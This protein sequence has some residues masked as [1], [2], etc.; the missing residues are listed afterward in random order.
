MSKQ[1]SLPAAGAEAAAPKPPQRSRDLLRAGVDAARACTAGVRLCRGVWRACRWCVL[2]RSCRVCVRRRSPQPAGRRRRRCRRTAAAAA[3]RRRAAQRTCVCRPPR[4]CARVR[5]HTLPHAARLTHPTFLRCYTVLGRLQAFVPQLAAANVALATAMATRPAHEFDVE[6]VQPSGQGGEA[7]PHI[8]MDI[9]C[10]V[11]ELRDEAAAAAAERAL[12]G[13][14]HPLPLASGF[15]DSDDDFDE[16][17]DDDDSEESDSD[18]EAM[19][20]GATAARGAAGDTAAQAR[21]AGAGGAAA[22]AGAQLGDAAQQPD[23]AHKRSRIQV[24]D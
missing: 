22:Q 8:E 15:T 7:A 17:D 2:T 23:S 9:A 18:A 11:L 19:E 6:Y 21:G 12:A 24:L 20:E 5:P 10:G 13:G 14:A 4:A 1:T 16:D 3:H